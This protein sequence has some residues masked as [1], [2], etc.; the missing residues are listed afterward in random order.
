MEEIDRPSLDGPDSPFEELRND[1][2]TEGTVARKIAL[3]AV[4]G[5][6]TAFAVARL[7]GDR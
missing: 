5:L 7:L 6:I 1:I 2:M 4:G 3:R